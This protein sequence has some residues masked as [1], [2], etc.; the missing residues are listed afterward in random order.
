[1]ISALVRFLEMISSL[2]DSIQEPQTFTLW[3]RIGGE[4]KREKM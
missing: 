2:D 3:Q 1:M 4:G